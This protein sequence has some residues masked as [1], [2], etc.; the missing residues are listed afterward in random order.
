MR[1][2]ENFSVFHRE[3]IFHGRGEILRVLREFDRP[4]EREASIGVFRGIELPARHDNADNVNDHYRSE[5]G[6]HSSVSS[7]APA[8][9]EP[10]TTIGFIFRFAVGAGGVPACT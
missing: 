7:A 5:H 6:F 9:I 10:P 2:K 8:M 1:V 4:Q 3:S